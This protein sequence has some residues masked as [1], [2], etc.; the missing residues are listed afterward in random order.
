MCIPVSASLVGAAGRDR[1]SGAADG[2]V[3]Q[4][5]AGDGVRRPDMNAA[6]ATS[7]GPGPAAEADAAALPSA[8]APAGG[9]QAPPAQQPPPEDA[10]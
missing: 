6:A 3:E 8:E 1:P 2:A 9:E 4:L 10:A 5:P 7:P